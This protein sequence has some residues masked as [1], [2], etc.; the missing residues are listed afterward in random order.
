MGQVIDRLV[1]PLSLMAKARRPSAPARPK[2][3]ARRCRR[4]WS[5]PSASPPPW[6]RAC[7]AG[8]AS[9]RARPSGSSAATSRAMPADA[10]RLAR[11]RQVA[12]AL[13]ARD[14]MGGGAERLAVARRLGLDGLRLRPATWPTKRARADLLLLA[15]AAL[16]VRGGERVTLL[17]SGS[18]ARPWPRRARRAWRCC[19]TRRHGRDR[20]RSARLRALAAPRPHRADRRFPGAAR[21]DPRAACALRRD[22]GVKGHLLQILDPAEET[23]PFAGR[24]RFEGLERED[25]L[26][27]SRVETVRDGLYRA[28]RAPPRRAR[29]AIARGAA[30]ASACTAPTSRRT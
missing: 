27:I 21:R 13:C 17:G 4:C 6:R 24:V 12:A 7:T 1:A 11:K 29:G 26:L 15:L 8:A 16:L 3:A 30:G 9:A 19:S 2:Q 23:L 10:H 18:G 20:R 14:R 5:R 22:A 25:P 28:A